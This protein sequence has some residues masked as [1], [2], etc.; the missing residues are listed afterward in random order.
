MEDKTIQV[1]IG[2]KNA[3]GE[4]NHDVQTLQEFIERET[5]FTTVIKGLGQLASAVA[6]LRPPPESKSDTIQ[7]FGVVRLTQM[8]N[9]SCFVDGVIDGIS[10]TKKEHDVSR[11][12]NLLL[13]VHE[14]G[15]LSGEAFESIGRPL[16]KIMEQTVDNLND[17]DNLNSISVRKVVPNC[18]VPLMIG[19][20]IALSGS[21]QDDFKTEGSDILCAGVVARTS[22]VGVNKKQVCTCSGKT[23]WEERLGRQR[24]E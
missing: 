7:T 5:G 8:T 1:E 22:T 24:R 4:P 14:Y 9:G 16:V 10:Q 2:T 21:F 12:M 17:G 11:N 3:K 23:L 18:N 20:S 6:E 15:D 19:K 13:A